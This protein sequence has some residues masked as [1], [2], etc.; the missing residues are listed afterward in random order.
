MQILRCN[1]SLFPSFFLSFKVARNLKDDSNQFMIHRVSLLFFISSL[2]FQEQFIWIIDALLY[3]IQGSMI[4]WKKPLFSSKQV[5]FLEN[6]L[7]CI[8]N[9]S[10]ALFKQKIAWHFLKP[11]GTF[12]PISRNALCARN[13]ETV[14]DF[15]LNRNILSIS[16]LLG[17]FQTWTTAWIKHERFVLSPAKIFFCHSIVTN[18]DFFVCACS[19]HFEKIKVQTERHEENFCV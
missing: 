1:H 14:L 18:I 2:L 17:E 16:R 8:R 15:C 12:L 19:F 9:W 3:F 5:Y 6:V 11:Q 13:K 4:H 10:K 7:F